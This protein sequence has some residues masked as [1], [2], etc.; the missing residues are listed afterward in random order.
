M[1]QP[2]SEYSYQVTH[3]GLIRLSA[4][5]M[6]SI[7]VAPGDVIKIVIRNGCVSI[8]GRDECGNKFPALV[9]MMINGP[10]LED[11]SDFTSEYK[12]K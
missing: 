2:D 1:H 7:G 5:A 6:D 10:V 9:K 12:P 3:E 4:E 8:E 11:E